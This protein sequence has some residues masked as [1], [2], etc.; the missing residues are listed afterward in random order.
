MIPREDTGGSA[1]TN[2]YGMSMQDM[3]E[4]VAGRQLTPHYTQASGWKRAGEL[5]YLHKSRLETYKERLSQAWPPEKSEAAKAYLA[6]L[7]ELILAVDDV[8]KTAT[9]NHQYSSDIPAALSEAQWKLKPIREEYNRIDQAVRNGEPVALPSGTTP[10]KYL[11]GKLNEARQV[12]YNLSAD[13]SLVRVNMAPP[14]PYLPPNSRRVD[15]GGDYGNGGGGGVMP[16]FIPP[17]VPI[18][19]QAVP[20]PSVGTGVLAP[21]PVAT[22]PDLTG[23][24]PTV[25]TP[26]TTLPGTP[27]TVGTPP[28][29]GGLPPT[30][31]IGAP[32]PTSP[33]VTGLP[34][35]G[36]PA[37]PV[38]GAPPTGGGAVPR[39][40]MPAG[41]VI[42]GAPGAGAGRGAGPAGA[43]TNPVGGM[44]GGGG[45]APG[46]GAGGVVSGRGGQAGLGPMGGMAGRPG[47]R[48]DGDDPDFDPDTQWSVDQ[49]VAPVL[50]APDTPG[51]VDPGPA[52]GLTR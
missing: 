48:R 26:T 52:I 30:G 2:W 5:A 33:T 13:L 18:G 43:R 16:P 27:P 17:V 6:K 39:G 24:A 29:T 51:P 4:M 1:G 40:A 8:A 20:P 50:D 25:P 3:W 46:R 15:S 21:V 31:L 10:E 38:I 49:G 32:P 37:G 45:G 7:D 44:I 35:G 14:K 36:R 22:G 11:Q 9:Q 19:A 23:L 12:M 42:G 34:P 41:G 47:Q 28:P